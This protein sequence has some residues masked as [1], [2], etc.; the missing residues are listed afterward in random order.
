MLLSLSFIACLD[1]WFRRGDD[2]SNRRRLLMNTLFFK[3]FRNPVPV[4]STPTGRGVEDNPFRSAS[5]SFSFFGADSIWMP[6]TG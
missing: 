6:A 1:L 3:C 4:A 5:G 2:E